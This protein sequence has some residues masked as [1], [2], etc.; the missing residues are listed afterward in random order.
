[1]KVAQSQAP[2]DLRF[3]VDSFGHTHKVMTSEENWEFYLSQRCACCNVQ[4][5]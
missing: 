5:R 4:Q 2:P 1:M 3:P